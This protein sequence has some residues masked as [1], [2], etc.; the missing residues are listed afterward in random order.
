MEKD[1][2]ANS[3][4]ATKRASPKGRSRRAMPLGSIGPRR[5]E[6]A[7]A[8]VPLFPVNAAEFGDHFG[9]HRPNTG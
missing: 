6:R 5:V 3:A 4:K 2:H 7:V 9:D 8:A 1:D